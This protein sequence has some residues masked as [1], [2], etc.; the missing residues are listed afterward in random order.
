MEQLTW[1]TD[2]VNKVIRR[3]TDYFTKVYFDK[4]E[5]R[6]LASLNLYIMLLNENFKE[7]EE[8]KNV[9]KD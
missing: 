7:E 3:T 5:F 1:T 4:M 2:E 6:D 8:A 9:G